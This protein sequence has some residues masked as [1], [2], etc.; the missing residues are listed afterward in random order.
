MEQGTEHCIKAAEALVT[1]L[2]GKRSKESYEK[3]SYS[4]DSLEQLIHFVDYNHRITGL[5]RTYKII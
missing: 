3:P 4:V 5:E 2:W 1:M